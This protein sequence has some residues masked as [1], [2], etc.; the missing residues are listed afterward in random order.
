MEEG[1][2]EFFNFSL[3]DYDGTQIFGTCLIFDEEPSDAF[4]YKLKTMY[5]KNIS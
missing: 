2:P 5:V 3:T 4:K 1:A